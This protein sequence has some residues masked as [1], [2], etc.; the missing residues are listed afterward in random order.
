MMGGDPARVTLRG[1]PPTDVT[2]T[3]NL[4]SGQLVGTPVTWTAT[5][6]S[7]S[8]SPIYRFSVARGNAP[9]RVVRDYRG[10][11]TFT[12]TPMAD[13]PYRIQVAVRD[14]FGLLE[15]TTATVWHNVLSRVSGGTPVVTATNNPLVA[16]YSAPPCGAA[17]YLYVAFRPVGAQRW[18]YTTPAPCQ[19]A[20]ST[21]LYVGGMRQQT[22]YELQHTV[23][24]AT[25]VLLGPLLSFATGAAPPLPLSGPM[26]TPDANT[27]QAEDLVL[28]ALARPLSGSTIWGFATDLAGR[29]VW[30]YDTVPNEAPIRVVPGGKM[31]LQGA[32]GPLSGY[33]L[34][35]IDLAGNS[36]RETNVARLNEQLAEL[37]KSPILEINH[38]AVR[39]PSG[40]TV[41]M[42][43][44][45]HLFENVQAA[46]GEVDVI[47]A[48]ALALDEDWQIVWSWDAFDHLDDLD[49][50]R[51]ATLDDKCPRANPFCPPLELAEV[52]NDWLHPNSIVLAPDGHLLLSL[53][54]QDWLIKID[55]ANGAGTGRVLWRLGKDGDFALDSGDPYPWFSHQHDASYVSPTQI[56]VFDNGNARCAS[57]ASGCQSRG[58]MYTIDESARRV[59]L[60]LN[61]EL[62]SYSNAW[63][64]AARL[65][66]GNYVFNSGKR[67][68]PDGGYFA[69]LVEVLPDGTLNYDMR[70]LS[71]VYRSF[72]VRDLYGR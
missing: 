57:Q 66:N 1:A 42:G 69:D 24:N 64:S 45:E 12:W 19:A 5:A 41:V 25:N 72:R 32:D 59:T 6:S 22:T 38:D 44:T 43:Y 21:N 27:S 2:L 29:P 40:L 51:L 18:D 33:I 13:G 47:G 31:L 35:E 52:G 20:V 34:R 55:F 3:P 11:N 61:A 7:T 28:H 62:G 67:P 36:L 54:S 39:L 4:P 10:T 23:S 70:M 60:D 26:N 53:R 16:L 8:G 30:Y 48:A 15:Q 50:N 46:N 63:G 68:Q 9:L 56:V 14:G 58:Q 37:G 49:I 17:A 71:G 65:S